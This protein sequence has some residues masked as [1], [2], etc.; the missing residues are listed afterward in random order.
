MSGLSSYLLS[1][2]SKVGGIGGGGGV[3]DF[4]YTLGERLDGFSGRTIWELHKAQSTDGKQEEATVFVFDKTRGSSYT[5]AA[6]NALKRMRTL[7]HPGVVR[8]LEGAETAEAIYIATEPVVPL[9]LVLDRENDDDDGSSS[10]GAGE[11]RRWGLFKV[12]EALRF[13]NDDCKLVHA[14]VSAASVF[15]TKAGEWRLAGFELMD[16]LESK[17]GEQHMYRHYTG[18]V[19]GYAARMAPEMESQDWSRVESGKLG[20]LDGWGLACLIHEL[21][22]G[23]AHSSAQMQTQGRIPAPLW[24]LCQRLRA[25]DL[26]RRMAPSE[27]LQAGQRPG[28]FLDSAFVNACRFIESIAVRE[29]DERADF[30]A[31][32]DATISG[33][34]LEFTK[35]K[36]LPELLKLV[37]FGG[38][39][40]AGSG[41]DAKVLSSIVQIGKGMG[42][43]EYNALIAP[44]IVQMFGSNDRALRFSLLEHMASFVQAIPPDLVAKKVFPNFATGFLDAAPAIREATVKASLAIAPKLSQKTLNNDLVRQL[45]RLVGDPEPGI[46]TNALICVGKLCTAKPG[47]LDL[48]SGGVSEASH[49]YVICPVLMQAMR[50]QFPPVRS[51][52]LAVVG[53]CAPKWEAPDIACRVIPTISPLLVDSEKPVRTAAFKALHAME[54]RIESHAQTMPDTQAKKQQASGPGAAAGPTAGVSA[55]TEAAASM[56]G[57]PDRWGGWA[58]SSLSSTI[59]GA[60]SLA[61]SLPIGQAL[62]SSSTSPPPT[63][64]TGEH[65]ATSTPAAL[66]R[67]PSATPV[68][69]GPAA[70]PAKA[71]PTLKPTSPQPNAGTDTKWSFNDDDWGNGSDGWGLDDGDD[72]LDT[73]EGKPVAPLA[74]ATAA[75]PPLK[76]AKPVVQRPA[77]STAG[78]GQATT[79][80]P[81]RKGLGAMK[82]GGQPKKTTALDDFL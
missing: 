26:R 2:L 62:G 67:T 15:V 52:A 10:E 45:V 21:Y 73:E 41:H 7:R 71:A 32:L 4:H 82:L 57:S 8:Y 24:P 51:A 75:K 47:V 39:G 37:E 44:A 72:D 1:T 13:T 28:A 18:V 55:Q 35:H 76:P 3:P 74:R 80:A 65:R 6:Q 78:S 20:A 22:N 53:A 43:A 69:S 48:D 25:P 27:F 16:A 23:A 66:G 61:S 30:F 38:I 29:D 9:V 81:R 31:N 40:R 79:A 33:F 58:V 70:A 64:S 5:V 34:P 42:D 60:L 54:A 49:R 11:L 19:P 59:S 77:S 56:A 63:P 17:P 50:D 46:R 68:N 14:N 36:I 12:A